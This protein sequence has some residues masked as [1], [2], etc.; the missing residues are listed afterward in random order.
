MKFNILDILL[1]RETKFYAY[2]SEQVDVL[3][4]G[5]KLFKEFVN[6]VENLNDE[7]FKKQITKIKEIEFK[8][9]TVEH[10]IIDELH[11]TFITPI[12]RE[13][14]HT[15]AINIDK[16]LDI[17]NSLSQ[18]FEIYRIHKFTPNVLKFADVIVEISIEL[19][20]LMKALADKGDIMKHVQKLHS[21]EN[22]ADHLFHWSIADLFDGTHD[23]IE[24]LK[25][26]EVYEHLENIVDCVDYVGKLIRGV[27]V[28]QG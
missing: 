8:G 16:A 14:I 15:I 25:F 1:P 13:D 21:L 23:P 24:V 26:K 19:S 2:M 27:K 10:K 18:K 11:K 6:N 3:I 17:L 20:Y 5:T 22:T 28:K 4:E 7:E 9:D 12:D